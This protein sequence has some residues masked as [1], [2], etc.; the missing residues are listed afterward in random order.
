MK[1]K[2]TDLKNSIRKPVSSSPSIFYY[3][4][5]DKD[6]RIKDT[7]LVIS[8]GRCLSTSSSCCCCCGG[9]GG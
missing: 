3:S 4:S 7:V 1:K 8:A 6:Y 9:G 5:N 2:Q